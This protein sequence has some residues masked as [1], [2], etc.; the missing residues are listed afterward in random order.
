[1]A[2]VYSWL[3]GWGLTALLTQNRS[4][5][6]CKFVRQLLCRRFAPRS[7]GETSMHGESSGIAHGVKCLV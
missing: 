1:M 5:R 6:A 3:V 4:Y 7:C 2:N